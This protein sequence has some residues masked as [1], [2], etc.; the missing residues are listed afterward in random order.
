MARYCC[1]ICCSKPKLYLTEQLKQ[2]PEQ[3]EA[4]LTSL[5]ALLSELQFLVNMLFVWLICATFGHLLLNNSRILFAELTFNSLIVF[6][7][8]EGTYT[9]SKLTTGKG[10]Y[11]STASEN[12]VMR[13]SITPWVLCSR[14]LSSTFADSGKKNL[15]HQRYI[16]EMDETPEELQAIVS[17]MRSFLAARETI[18]SIKNQ[19]DLANTEHIHQFNQQSRAMPVNNEQGLLQQ[20]EQDVAA[21]QQQLPPKTGPEPG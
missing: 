15:E 21:S 5:Q 4:Y 9:E 1:F 2:L 7:K 13:A 10:I 17:D 12:Y 18:A 19:Q 14:L 3:S 20:P 16:L 11:D 6:L 8:C